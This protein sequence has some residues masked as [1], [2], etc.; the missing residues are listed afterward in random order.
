L[1]GS[2]RS[3]EEHALE[4]R[5][6]DGQR[7][8]T[9]VN[10]NAVYGTVGCHV[11]VR[12]ERPSVGIEHIDTHDARDPDGVRP[13]IERGNLGNLPRRGMAVR[14]QFGEGNFWPGLRADSL[15]TCNHQGQCDGPTQYKPQQRHVSS[16]SCQ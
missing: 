14:P 12:H 13:A 2:R 6:L 11:D 7:R 4:A 8:E 16:R 1:P 3:H 15:I 9:V 5:R 10:S